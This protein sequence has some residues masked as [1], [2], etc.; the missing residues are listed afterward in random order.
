MRR[1]NHF[2]RAL[3]LNASGIA[4]LVS[5]SSAYAQ[6]AQPSATSPDSAQTAADPTTAASEET[7][8]L[9][10]I[11]VTAQRRE[12]NLQRTAIAISAIGGDDLVNAGVSDVTNLS[13]LV[14]A[15]VVQPTVGSSTNFYLRG[16][17]SFA[18]NAFTENPIA[19]NFNGV[20]IARPTAPLGTFYDLE[21]V[22]VLKGPQGT[23]YGRNATGGAINVIPKRPELGRFGVD[24]VAEYGNY[25]TK[26]FMA[27]V[28]IPLGGKAAL[29][30]A[31]QVVDRDAYLSDGY[32]D[33][34]GQAVRAS[35]Y[36]EPNDWLSGTIVAD[37][38]HQG[39]K[40]TG[41]V[42]IPGP[43]TPLAPPPSDR[44]GNSDPLSVAA[45]AAAF[46][47][48]VP[49][50]LVIAPQQDGYVDGNF[51]GVAATINADLGFATLTVVPAYRN[52]QPKFR[53]YNAGYRFDAEEH[54]NQ[55]SLEVR[56]ASSSGGRLGY[57]VGGYLFDEKQDAFNN[58]Y[59]GL[60]LDTLFTP[61]IRNKSAAVFG[62]LTYSLTDTLRIVGGGR[63]TTEKKTQA[64]TFS[65]KAFGVGPTSVFT[66]EAKFNRATYKAGVE[67]DAGSRSLMYA[68]M[69]T[70]FKS[71]GF[72]IAPLDN[73]FAPEKLTAYTIGAKNRFLD[74]RLQLNVEGFYW[75]YQ[76]QQVN[77]I[78]AIRT[79]P[80]TTGQGLVTTNAGRS[81][82]YGAEVEMRFQ[83]SRNDLF[84]AD[85]QYLN[86][87]YKTFSYTT[88]S[89]TGAPPRTNCTVTPAASPVTAAPARA[90][91]VD[92]SGRP[93]VNSPKWTFNAAYEHTFELPG[94][95]KLVGSARTRIE[96]G[97]FLSTE[98][99]P[100]QYQ[101]AYRSS[102]A[103]LA[104]YGPNDLWS[105]TGFVNNIENRTIYGGSNLRP[106][107]PVVFNILRPPRT[108]G[109]R[110][111]FNY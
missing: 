47:T 23:L 70:G 26:K 35:L 25:D 87:Q 19:F 50:G 33:E 34:K 15:L 56:L 97:R 83:L 100:E 104:L 84:S 14:P 94:D 17:G 42:L 93:Q 61:E 3:A 37:Y 111:G 2:S 45:L 69:A 9:T 62:Q 58:A 106:I 46:P 101:K 24:A 74:N 8:G 7:D 38:F 90:L 95:L 51:W 107:A 53:S 55:K 49:T 4:L 63:Y 79:S 72:F 44:I 60:L 110:L 89:A 71:G 43:L 12:E 41:G 105:I 96:S 54:T 18:A 68:N 16:V 13:K 76:D 5:A 86:G 59:Q 39:G 85:L 64:T 28:N 103:Y 92:C 67:F 29:R 21:R 102:D 30:V 88:I 109:V 27:A 99:L 91:I 10:D 80:T 108:Y 32:D 66:G 31:G 82:I 65:Q 6:E 22:E 73:T 11:V 98:Y 81:R 52:T 77:Y 57:V 1:F 48:L 20:Y 78:G 40:G 36:V 75:D